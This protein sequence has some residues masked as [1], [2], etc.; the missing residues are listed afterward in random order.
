MRNNKLTLDTFRDLALQ[1]LPS[2]SHVWLYGSRARGEAREDSD[3]DLLILIN[4]DKI[5]HTDEDKYSYPFVDLGWEFGSSVS[6]QLYTFDEW[7]KRSITP[8]YKNAEQD[9]IIIL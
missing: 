5:T 7:A 1:V 2:S 9:K 3:W 8:Y 4:K 6:P